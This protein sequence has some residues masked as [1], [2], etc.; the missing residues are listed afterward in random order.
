MHYIVLADMK[1]VLSSS[2]ATMHSCHLEELD[3]R[4]N[5]LPTVL[6]LLRVLKEDLS[7]VAMHP[8]N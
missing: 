4:E 7:F 8:N 6:L 2:R 1:Y 5:L 3:I